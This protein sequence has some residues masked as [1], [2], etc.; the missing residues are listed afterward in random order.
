[1]F[2]FEDCISETD[3][4][5]GNK[6]KVNKNIPRIP[7]SAQNFQLKR[8]DE[9]LSVGVNPISPTSESV[10]VTELFEDARSLRSPGSFFSSSPPYDEYGA[11]PARNITESVAL[12]PI[13]IA[14]FNFI[15][16]NPDELNMIDQEIMFRNNLYEKSKE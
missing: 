16:E 9:T 3:S 11:S 14:M 12:H 5:L 8:L 7:R 2:D 15:A 4:L 13:C 6:K 10:S 1:M